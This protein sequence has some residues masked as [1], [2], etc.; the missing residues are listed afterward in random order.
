MRRR[1]ASGGCSGGITLPLLR[2]ILALV[3]I[4]TVIGS[5]QVFDTVAV[6]TAGGPAERHARAPVLHLRAGLRPLP[7]RLRLGDVGRPAGRSSASITFAAVPAHRAPANRTWA[8]EETD[9]AADTPDTPARTPA[10][11]P[12]APDE[13]RLRLGRVA[14]W[15]SWAW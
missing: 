7:V 2:P 4:I 13:A 1:R 15:V 6:T 10:T 8:E 11:G 5:F 3:L 14:A 9:M 12:A